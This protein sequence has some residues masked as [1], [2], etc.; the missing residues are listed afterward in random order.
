MAAGDTEELAFLRTY[1]SMTLRKPQV[2]ADNVLAGIFLADAA[3][4]AALAGLLL[5]EAVEAARRLAAVWTALSDR[6]MPVARRLEQPLPGAASWRALAGRVG[7]TEQADE[8]LDVLGIGEGA[9][10]SAEELMAFGGL[11]WFE[12]AIRTAETGPPDVTVEAPESGAAPILAWRGRDAAGQPASV[13]LLLED[14]RVVA[15]GDA[16]AD[17]V[18]WAREFL[19]TY[20]DARTPGHEEPER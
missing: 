12:Q 17:F 16:T 1:E 3:H 13:R 2:V 11:T 4:R 5:Q 15:L 14:S 10:E 19:A 6:T 20:I 7:M 8:I 18:M 9:R